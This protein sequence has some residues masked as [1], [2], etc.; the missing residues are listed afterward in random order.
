VS[1]FTPSLRPALIALAVWAAFVLMTA[2]DWI[3]PQ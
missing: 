1:R 3:G 2:T